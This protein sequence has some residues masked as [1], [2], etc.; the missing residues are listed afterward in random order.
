MKFI[1]PFNENSTFP[2]IERI[3][4]LTTFNGE[5]IKY[6]LEYED[7]L[8]KSFS[9][10]A[11]I[12]RK[13]DSIISEFED[14]DEGGTPAKNRNLLQDEMVALAK[15]VIA[16][17][18]SCNVGVLSAYC[19]QKM[20]IVEW[21]KSDKLKDMNNKTGLFE[22]VS[23]EDNPEC[24]FAQLRNDILSDHMIFIDEINKYLKP[25][26]FEMKFVEILNGKLGGHYIYVRIN[27]IGMVFEGYDHMRPHK[28]TLEVW[29]IFKNNSNGVF[30]NMKDFIEFYKQHNLHLYELGLSKTGIFK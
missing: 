30:Y 4:E 25:K 12:R 15:I 8:E 3:L 20:D 16:F 27:D 1:K 14:E 10:L 22:N 2:N 24:G 11:I 26:G 6:W 17:K 21:S 19:A 28:N 9:D 18:G 5:T 29:D 23:F 7:P 13:A